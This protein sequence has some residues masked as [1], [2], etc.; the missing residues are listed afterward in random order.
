MFKLN[1]RYLNSLKGSEAI[2]DMVAAGYDKRKA[3]KIILKTM[4]ESPSGG[5]ILANRNMVT[6]NNMFAWRDT[7]QGHDFWANIH[8]KKYLN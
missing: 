2:K 8:Y 5:V 1:S 3:V 7:K 4:K 6:L